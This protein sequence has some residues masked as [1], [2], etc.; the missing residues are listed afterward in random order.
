MKLAQLFLSRVLRKSVLQSEALR[1]LSNLSPRPPT[2]GPFMKTLSRRSQVLL[3]LLLFVL[4]PAARAQ[5]R[6][7]QC[8]TVLVF[9]TGMTDSGAPLPGASVDPRFRGISAN[10]SNTPN[11]YVVSNVPSAWLSN[12][13]SVESKW[14]APGANPNYP[15]GTY[16]YQLT[17]VTP[18][19]NA[20]VIGRFAAGDRGAVRLNGAGAFIS[21]SATGYSNWT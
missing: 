18:C 15:A 19:V 2:H 5:H 4:V 3:L 20:R 9:G 1:P 10:F 21:T 17:F 11:A 14:I 8:E 6:T 12:N 16:Q 7:N 13:L